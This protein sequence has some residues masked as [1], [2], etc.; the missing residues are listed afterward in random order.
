[1]SGPEHAVAFRAGDTRRRPGRIVGA[2]HDLSSVATGAVARADRRLTPGAGSPGVAGDQP[3]D[4]GHRRN[5]LRFGAPDR[6]LGHLGEQRLLGFLDDGGATLSPDQAQSRTAV[7]EGSRQDHADYSL[8]VGC[9]G[10]A[11][12][13][14][15]RRAV[16]LFF[17]STTQRDPAPLQYQMGIG[18]CDVNSIAND[19]LALRRYRRDERS[20]TGQD[21]G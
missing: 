7:V 16:S 14:I 1:G 2:N 9:R 20:A 21:R 13:R 12:Q 19:G 18:R 17:R 4:F 10:A 3:G 8:S 6:I 15:D 11:K 5:V